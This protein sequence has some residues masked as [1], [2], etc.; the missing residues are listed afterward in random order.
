VV[1]LFDLGDLVNLVDLV[2]LSDL[3]DLVDLGD[4]CD[5]VDLVN[6]VDL[7]TFIFSRNFNRDISVLAKN[8]ASEEKLHASH[9]LLLTQLLKLFFFSEKC[10]WKQCINYKSS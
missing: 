1:D 7:V 4:L 10:T 8:P 2:S 3:G 9:I 6:L 5:L